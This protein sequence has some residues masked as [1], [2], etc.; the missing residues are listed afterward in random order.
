MLFLE[1]FKVIMYIFSASA[2]L[3]F[4]KVGNF[5]AVKL[6]SACAEG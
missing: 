2:K 6:G 1:I 5:V 3:S 4:S